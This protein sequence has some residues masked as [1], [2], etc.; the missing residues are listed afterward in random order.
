MAHHYFIKYK[1]NNFTRAV[2][3][4]T[5]YNE[6]RALLSLKREREK[7]LFSSI[8]SPGGEDIKNIGP[9]ILEVTAGLW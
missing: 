4:K 3:L 2:L 1:L 6:A 5:N 9:C 7:V 8:I